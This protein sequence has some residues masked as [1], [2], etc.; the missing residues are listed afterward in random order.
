MQMRVPLTLAA[1]AVLLV[2]GTPTSAHGQ[3]SGGEIIA[4]ML[5][6]FEERAQGVEDY[7]LVQESMGTENTIYHEKRL[8]DNY[9]IYVP[10]TDVDLL[11]KQIGDIKSKFHQLAL[12][13]GMRDFADHLAAGSDAQLGT[14]FKRIADIASQKMMPGFGCEK[15]EGDDD[16]ASATGDLLKGVLLQA[17]EDAAFDAIMGSIMGSS[18]QQMG[19]MGEL[20]GAFGMGEAMTVMED[21]SALSKGGVPG[22]GGPS[23]GNL[24]EA[25]LSAAATTGLG[26]VVGQVMMPDFENMSLGMRTGPPDARGM[27][28]QIGDRAR[29]DGTETIDGHETWLLTVPDPAELDLEDQE[30]FT[31]ESMSFNVDRELY[32]LRRASVKGEADFDGRKG[33]MAISVR[34]EDYRDV[35]TLLLPFHTVTAIDGLQSAMSEEDRKMLADMDE[36]LAKMDEQLKDLP[37]EQRAMAES[38]LKAQMPQLEQMR[39]AAA[40]EGP[41]ELAV[42][43]LE[44]RVNTGPPEVDK[45]LLCPA[46][47]S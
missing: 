18:D 3:P 45:R 17:A 29:V 40:N 38:M 11:L 33:P 20:F 31:P 39:T 37:P 1:A 36:Q 34:F 16:L 28:R 6:Q 27:M 4:E 9:P 14:F 10:M 7:T 2:F 22:L 19:A 42:Q 32:V 41:S 35:G 15:Q 23:M 5:A 12:M 24:A 44:A 21:P 13:A 30:D 47:E 26:M 25:G 8:V 46:E 43:V